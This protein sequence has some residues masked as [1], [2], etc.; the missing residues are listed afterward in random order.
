MLATGIAPR[1]WNVLCQ[2]LNFYL[3]K[4][5]PIEIFDQTNKLISNKGYFLTKFNQHFG[6][7]HGQTRTPEFEQIKQKSPSD[8]RLDYC[9]GKR[10]GDD[11]MTNY[12]S[13]FLDAELSTIPRSFTLLRMITDNRT[14]RT[15]YLERTI[16]TIRSR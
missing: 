13:M 4:N 1:K 7:S 11:R 5:L 6:T 10:H 2:H 3:F 15:W 8:L 12:V 16:L 9:L 14:S